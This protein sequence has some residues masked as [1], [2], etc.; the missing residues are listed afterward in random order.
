MFGRLV[1]DIWKQSKSESPPNYFEFIQQISLQE[2]LVDKVLFYPNFRKISSFLFDDSQESISCRRELVKMVM[3]SPMNPNIEQILLSKNILRNVAARKLQFTCKFLETLVL[4][5]IQKKEFQTTLPL[6]IDG[7]LDFC[8]L[9]MEAVKRMNF[10]MISNAVR[11]SANSM[12]SFA[13]KG[14]KEET[15]KVVSY[16]AFDNIFRKSTDIRM[17]PEVRVSIDLLHGFPYKAGVSCPV[18]AKAV[19]YCIKSDMFGRILVEHAANVSVSETNHSGDS[20]WHHVYAQAEL[21]HYALKPLES[22]VVHWTTVP[23][24]FDNRSDSEQNPDNKNPIKYWFPESSTVRT[25]YIY[26]DKSFQNFEMWTDTNT[27]IPFQMPL[28]SLKRKLDEML[29]TEATENTTTTV[30]TAPKVIDWSTIQTFIRS[31]YKSEKISKS[32]YTKLIRALANKDD[33]LLNTYQ[34]FPDPEAEQSSFVEEV[35]IILED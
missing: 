14:P 29:S 10:L 11:K 30:T 25:V 12:A 27:C 18:K 23:N 26:H 16:N 17:E 7:K 24:G 33:N 21:Y 22:W 5:I 4:N 20:L 3:G 13:P 34:S 19:D 8:Q 35:T 9:L 1:D 2:N 15:Y 6:K 31:L 32:L 28:G